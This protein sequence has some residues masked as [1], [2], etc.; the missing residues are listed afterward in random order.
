MKLKSLYK[1]VLSSMPSKVAVLVRLIHT[2]RH[3]LTVCCALVL[4]YGTLAINTA[5]HYTFCWLVVL[6]SIPR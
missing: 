3:T 2:P 1:S 4:S 6:V 5:E